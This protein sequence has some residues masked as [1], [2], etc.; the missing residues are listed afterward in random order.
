MPSKHTLDSI[1][2]WNTGD[3]SAYLSNLEEPPCITA[4]LKRFEL[5]G[6]YHPSL[7]FDSDGDEDDESS[8]GL[9]TSSHSTASPSNSLPSSP[10]NARGCATNKVPEKPTLCDRRPRL[11]RTFSFNV[12]APASSKFITWSAAVGGLRHKA[13][14]F[15]SHAE[16]ACRR[17]PPQ[18]AVERT[19]RV[20]D[21]AMSTPRD[22]SFC[23][24]SAA[25][26]PL[27][28]DPAGEK[29]QDSL[30][31]NQAAAGI[32]LTDWG[33]REALRAPCVDEPSQGLPAT[34]A[35]L[36]SRPDAT[37][38]NGRSSR[39]GQLASSFTARRHMAALQF[40]GAANEA[41]H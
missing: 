28:V 35:Q 38:P 30:L 39:S 33:G 21:L 1:G 29:W 9:D 19:G 5:D 32:P 12:K 27:I 8:P 18:P 7:L 13:P 3:Q 36:P 17:S 6:Y 25:G 16:I 40:A 24:R 11:N 14:N 22:L 15:T 4:Q 2:G 41:S 10:G 31:P 20:Q 34:P 26:S 37:H 23:D